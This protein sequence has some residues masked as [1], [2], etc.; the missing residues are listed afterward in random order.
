M[1]NSVI[2]FNQNLI[3]IFNLHNFLYILEPSDSDGI[4]PGRREA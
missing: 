2:I 4:V 1:Y 3:I